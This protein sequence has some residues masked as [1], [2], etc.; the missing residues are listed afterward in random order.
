MNHPA[1]RAVLFAFLRLISYTLLLFFA[2]YMIRLDAMAPANE[3]GLKF[4]ED[5][6]TEYAQ[7][8]ML[9]LSGLLYAWLAI[10]FESVRAFAILFAGLCFMAL[11]RE[12]NNYFH[13]LFKGA[14]QIAVAII[15]IVTTVLVFRNRQSFL[16]PFQLFLQT[17]AFGL[18][19]AAA[20][21]I[22]LFSRLFG[23]KS[24]WENILEVD[25]LEGAFRS[26]KNA[27]EEGIELL[28]YSLLLI[29]AIEF[30][31]WVYSKLNELP[32][33]TSPN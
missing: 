12:F 26:V 17:P 33:K 5:S 10:R 24:T 23:K 20:L 8:I 30:T 7:E 2:Y 18:N 32:E 29:G 22:L 28:G 11:F 15:L 25:E 16:R 21:I 31:I 6:Y 9:L 3:E 1:A 19:I 14:W 13:E 4:L 27:A